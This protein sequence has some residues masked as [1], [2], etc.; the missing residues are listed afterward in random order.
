MTSL[1]LNLEDLIH[2]R[3]VED[4]R[5]EFQAAWDDHVKVAVTRTVCAFANDLL[6]LN[7]GYLILGIETDASGVPI[8]PPRGMEGGNLDR[9]QREIR[10]QCRRLD[11]QYQPVLS[12][13]TYQG[14]SILVIWAPGGD[15]RPYQDII[16]DLEQALAR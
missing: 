2:A 13:E 5:R 4:N 8:L 7:G 6:N 1:P 16:A 11:P 15:N 12:V 14:R 10:G 3:A 9:I